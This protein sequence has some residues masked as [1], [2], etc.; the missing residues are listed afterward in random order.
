MSSPN[1]YDGLVD[2]Y[3]TFSDQIELCFMSSSSQFLT[4]KIRIFFVLTLMT[5]DGA[6]SWRA[7]VQ[8]EIRERIYVPNSWAAFKDRLDQRF[9]N[10]NQRLE[11][12]AEI[13]QMRQGLT[14]PLPLSLTALMQS[15]SMRGIMMR[16]LFNI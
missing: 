3:K 1:E 11:A 14:K 4:D 6:A 9:G 16:Q 13:D 15:A 12:Q 8:N 2:K 10:C 5:K 7:Q